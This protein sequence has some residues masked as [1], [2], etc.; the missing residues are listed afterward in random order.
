MNHIFYIVYCIIH[1]GNAIW[2][3][4]DAI[5][6]SVWHIAAMV[7]HVCIKLR[8]SW[9][10]CTI[11]GDWRKQVLLN[12]S[13]NTVLHR[14]SA[15][16][17]TINSITACYNIVDTWNGVTQ[18]LCGILNSKKR[19]AEWWEEYAITMVEENVVDIQCCQT[20]L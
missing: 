6:P 15:M 1:A 2:T 12:I 7:Y 5:T 3:N 13:L 17:H 18:S 20:F 4:E 9:P 19:N 8:H 14:S 11:I 16:L 10:L